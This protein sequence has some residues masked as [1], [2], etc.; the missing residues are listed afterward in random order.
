MTADFNV[1]VVPSDD[2]SRIDFLSEKFSLGITYIVEDIVLADEFNGV[3][4]KWDENEF[5]DE[6][7]RVTRPDSDIQTVLTADF[8]YNDTVVKKEFPI[9]VAGKTSKYLA[10]FV[11]K[12]EHNMGS[13][14]AEFPSGV[15]TDNARTDM[16]Y[17]AVSDTPDGEYDV[18]NNGKAVLSA[19][20][21]SNAFA[22]KFSHQFGSPR[23][24]RKADG[25]YGMIASNNN[26]TPYAIVYD[27][28]DLLFFDGQ[29][30]LVLNDDNIA[31]MNPYVKYDNLNMVYKIYWQGSDGKS[32]VSETADLITVIK[33]AEADYVKD[34]FAGTLPVYADESEASV[35]ELTQ[36]EY[37]RI[38]RKYGGIYSVSV[39]QPD[40]I[41]LNGS[42]SLEL[43]E[44]VT[45]NYSDGSTKNLGV[46]WDLKGAG[47]NPD[48]PKA[49]TYEIKGKINRTLNL[50][51]EDKGYRLLAQFR[52][53][54]QVQY[55]EKDN[56]YYFTSSY[57]QGDCNNAY[58]YVILRSS[59]TL[60]GLS[61]S[62]G[63]KDNEVIIW[64]QD[65]GVTPDDDTMPWYWAPELHYFGG[66]Y[67]VIFLSTVYQKDGAGE[68][69]L[70]GNGN[71]MT[72][73][74]MT[75][76]SCDG[77]NDPMNPDNWYLTGHVNPDSNGMY[78]GAFDTT[79]FKYNGQ[80]Y[81]VS[82]ANSAIWIAEFDENDPLNMTTNLVKISD[83][84]RPWEYNIGQPGK[85]CDHQ[86]IEEASYVMVHEGRIF[87]TYACSTVDNHYAIGLLYADLDS[88]LTN[89]DNWHKYPYP[90][91]AT[92]DLTETIVEPKFTDGGKLISEGEYEGIFG[93]GHN[94]ITYDEYG[95]P[96]AVFHARVWGESYVDE[97][98]RY[99]L[100]DPGRHAFAT[101]VHFGADGFPILTMTP[102]QELS[103]ELEEITIKVTVGGKEGASKKHFP[104][105]AVI[106]LCA[107]AAAAVSAIPI[108]KKKKK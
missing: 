92:S 9:T 84:D 39:N 62:E 102:E 27:S 99:G 85:P 10:S 51:A 79:F 98:A 37:D 49:G 21:D 41:V 23:L 56:K 36:E 59:D 25:T 69:K 70:D 32:Y 75:I 95:N 4:I 6:N 93:P 97:S 48:N 40:D 3:S 60:T 73:W 58:R 28:D 33:T 104:L 46:S 26:E 35:F 80:C 8:C 54:P 52:A 108:I 67:N 76:I 29:R 31:V 105:A 1:F 38:S 11:A 24:F 19:V 66:K 86:Y 87:I 12:Y 16:M 82:P 44:T 83:A 71:K 77:D 47:L 50:G 57:M 18:L 61:D 106:G 53:D 94:S 15:Y 78:P 17:Y 7:G 22:V 30:N 42:E 5:I 103:E 13:E 74:R 81:Y 64:N 96:I 91:L 88:D 45:V 107:A 68:I 20:S 14:F 34:E 55:V 72:M 101:G 65:A 89:P 2:K 63:G 90:L 43:P 100:V